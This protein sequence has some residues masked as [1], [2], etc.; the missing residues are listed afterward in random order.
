VKQLSISLFDFLS[1][2]PFY[3]NGALCPNNMQ[4]RAHRGVAISNF[5]TPTMQISFG[6]LQSACATACRTILTPQFNDT[7]T[8]GGGNER[9]ACLSTMFRIVVACPVMCACTIGLES[10]QSWLLEPASVHCSRKK[11]RVG[12]DCVK[13]AD[14]IAPGKLISSHVVYCK[15]VTPSDPQSHRF[16]TPPEPPAVGN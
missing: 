11:V 12:L 14:G 13:G 10:M 16:M 9:Q 15:P 5:D 2:G 3:K 7:P 8:H 1:Q 4:G 6:V